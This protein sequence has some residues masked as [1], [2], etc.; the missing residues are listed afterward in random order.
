MKAEAINKGEGEI[1]IKFTA[2]A[3]HEALMLSMAALGVDENVS[4]NLSN[5]GSGKI[6]LGLVS[7]PVIKQMG[8]EEV[9][10]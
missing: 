6:T 9:P 2:V 8:K 5:Q 4:L 10:F 3:P 7:L 1:T